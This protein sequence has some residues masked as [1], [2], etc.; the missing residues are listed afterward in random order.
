M[1]QSIYPRKQG[2]YD[3]ASE[4]DAC[5]VGFVV[6]IDGRKSHTIIERGIEVLTKLLHRGAAGEDKKTGDGAGIL[7][8]I[9]HDFFCAQC[10][11]LKIALGQEGTYGVGM[12]F[13]PQETKMLEKCQEIT[14][15]VACEEGFEFLGWREVPVDSSAVGK[16]AREKQPLIVQCFVRHDNL[17]EE[18]LE[19]K[20]Y[21]TRKQV[22]QRIEKTLSLGDRFYIVS[23]SS[24]TIVYKG[25]MM[26]EQISSFY[27]D[28]SDPSFISAMAV[29]HQRYSTNTFPSWKLAQPFRYLAHNGEINTLRGNLNQMRAREN[30]L[31]SDDFG[32]DIKKIL[33][34]IDP[35]GSDSAC[36]DNVLELLN[37]AGRDLAH[38]MMMLIPQAWGQKYPIGPD[39]KGFFEYHAGL[40]EPWDGPAAVAFSDGSVIG[41][42]LD[43]NGLRPARY[44]IT[45]NN[46]M[47]LASE[48]GVLD[49]A[50]EGILEKGALRPGD[51]I[52]VDLNKKRVL[53]NNEIKTFYARRQP[54]RRWVEENKILLHG[55]F[56]DVAPVSLD[57]ESLLTREKLFGYTLEDCKEIINPMASRGYE[58]VGSMGSDIP[59]AVF[60][61][62]PQLLY[63]YFKQLF[64]QITNPAI[65]PIRE[66][67]V[68]SL[69]TFIGNPGN[70][71]SEVPQNSN[72]IK[73]MH[74]IL[75]NEDLERVR[76]L[77]QKDFWA[78]T[79]QMG[80]AAGGSG[81]TLEE[82]LGQLCRAAEASVTNGSSVIILSDR[83]LSKDLAPIP[84]LLAVSAVNQ[85]LIRQSMKTNVGIIVETGGAREIQH[86]A[87][88][89]AFGATAI[90]P[91]LAFEVVTAMAL[92]KTLEKEMDTTKAI[93]NYIKAICKGLLKVMSKMGISTLR[94]YRGAQIFEAIGLTYDVIE[95]YFTGTSSR[96]D[97]IGLNEIAR[98]ANAR[99]KSAYDPS[100]ELGSLP[101]GGCYKYRR[102]GERHLWTP[103][104]ISQLQFAT[105][106]NN[107]KI[108]KEYA[109]LIN[110][111]T[112][113]ISTLRGLFQ[114]KKTEPIPIEDVEPAADIIKRFATSAMSFGS[115]SR[116]AHE[117]LAIAMNRLGAMSNSGEGGEDPARYKL[118]PNG[119]NRSSAVKQ[120]ASG[121]F[122]VTAEYCVNARELQIKIAQGAKPGEGGQLPGHKVNEEIARV[123]HS[124][125]GVTLI[126]PPP[127]HDVYSIED[128]KQL[129]FDLKNANPAARI[130]V[131]LVSETGVGTIAA[132]VAKAH[133]DMVL[134]SGY[135][136][137]TGASPLSSI[138]HAGVPWE[139]GLAETQ[140]TLVLNGLRS[141]IRVQT[142]GQLK[143]GRDVVI[144]ALLGAEE[145]GFATAPL[146]V[147]GC[148]MMRKCHLNTCPVGV[149][150]Q[151][152][153]LRKRFKGK[154]E[155]VVNFFSFIAQE[156][157]EYMAQLGIRKIDDLIGRTD[158]LEI[159]EAINFWK[160]KGLDFSRILSE[161]NPD[162]AAIR[163]CTQSQDHE[164]DHVLDR[165]L[166]ERSSQSLENKKPVKIDLPIRNTHLT[167]GAMLSGEI[168]KRYGHQGLPD[169]TITCSFQGSAG[170]S[171]GAFA[172]KGLTFILEG[173]AND[174][175][176]KGMCGGKIIM[177]PLKGCTFDPSENIICGNVLL[178][179]ATS[180][181]IYIHGR[182]GERFAIR[183]SGAYAV[184]E[185]IGDHGCE[186][187]TGGRVVVLGETG[188]N[189]AAGMSG[190]I[191][192][193]YDPNSKLDGRTNLDMVD[194]ELVN[195]PEDIK[196][197]KGMIERHFKYTASPKARYILDHWEESLPLFVKVFPME[198]RRVLGKMS[199]ED[200]EIEREET[201]MK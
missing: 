181:E 142:D 145:F 122:G 34:V 88:L 36:L 19:R 77:N 131:K 153:E 143:T 30:L 14:K 118:L 2:L 45:K 76:S 101:S 152:P 139:L 1:S 146:V 129:I 135:D 48:A 163:R 173:E 39:L 60:S 100:S 58:P 22:E 159:N 57:A 132:G 130:S 92:Q 63:A 32:D 29:I 185:G 133:A 35:G 85:Y 114:F 150:T 116:E 120:V 44:T 25:M 9:P 155:Y 192:Y 115:I 47:V 108:Y 107:Y 200:E 106:N 169:D 201:V 126:S 68:M 90:N 82:S 17:R 109:Q 105:R 50:P 23:L 144:A 174:Y 119:D 33:P 167:T 51:I 121:R 104:S 188:I 98:E 127:H 137:G 6:N 157:R 40:M 128:I 64:A 4:H 94:S 124:T 62:K 70:I 154:P 67:L 117:T 177:K 91:Y 198:Y 165:E 193:V 73:L 113:K 148:V 24:R 54:Y 43:R 55:L 80:F 41:A 74:P 195:E 186:Y 99:H 42:L 168:A 61:E 179:G 176:G 197:L 134:I 138:R 11:S 180:G 191:A 112:K 7:V 20:L 196:E 49:F 102:D 96:I 59:L 166:I 31:E 66:E 26:G 123:R 21:V 10:S 12:I 156:V 171:F 86:F 53:K 199:K 111:Q 3:P 189:F 83:N 161:N 46:F 172:A 103:E 16:K 136:G 149:A 84:A 78:V 8:Q 65:D 75:S 141:R 162:T 5:G 95:Q 93:E 184:V 28:L 15:E 52:L 175:C 190:G 79:L 97:G 87:L 178:Y 69:M 18:A 183:N 182:A 158:L 147:C 71:L 89:L 38:A 37:S 72:L 125:P 164:I 27:K 170:Q 56:N 194:L 140:Q 81:E 151:D 13:M 110:N 160:A 187:M